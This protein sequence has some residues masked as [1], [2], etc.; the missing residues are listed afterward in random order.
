MR[1]LR[2]FCVLCCL[3]CVRCVQWKLRLTLSEVADHYGGHRQSM[4]TG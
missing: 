2:T 1:L 4:S 3:R